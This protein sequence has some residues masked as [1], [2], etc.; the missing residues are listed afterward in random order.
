[1]RRDLAIDNGHPEE[2]DQ[3]TICFCLGHDA[4]GLALK[5][6]N[7]AQELTRRRRPRA[8]SL[9][10]PSIPLFIYMIFQQGSLT[11]DASAEHWILA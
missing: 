1:M 11:K 7:D 8:Y 2:H 10:I 4:I 5:Q 9:T 3:P 6:W